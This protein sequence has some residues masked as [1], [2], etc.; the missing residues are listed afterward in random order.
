MKT[1]LFLVIL[2]S[3]AVLTARAAEIRFAPEGTASGGLTAY[4]VQTPTA[5]FFL[6]RTGAGLSSMLDRDGHD[7]LSFD[8]GPGSGGEYRGFP[9]AIH[10]QAGSHFH[11][12]FK[13]RTYFANQ[14]RHGWPQLIG[15]RIGCG[16]ESS[17]LDHSPGQAEYPGNLARQFFC[18]TTFG[19]AGL[20]RPDD[21]QARRRERDPGSPRK[22]RRAVARDCRSA[23]V[24][25]QAKAMIRTA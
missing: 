22:P 10:Q 13:F 19:S 1:A 25:P 18:V 6:E 21:R 2:L 14:T 4:R 12:K 15:Y 20:F 9:N 7:W 3:G 8:P 23:G 11:P 5:T 16:R 17:D 24:L